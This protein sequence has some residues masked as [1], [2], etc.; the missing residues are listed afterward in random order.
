[1]VT[2][3]YPIIYNSSEIKLNLR[4]SFYFTAEKQKCHEINNINIKKNIPKY[5]KFR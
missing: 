1:M 4:F 5:H 2:K 3:L